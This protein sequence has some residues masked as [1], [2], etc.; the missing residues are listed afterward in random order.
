VEYSAG[1]LR[2]RKLSQEEFG[3]FGKQNSGNSN[4]LLNIS[5][6]GNGSNKGG[7]N[8]SVFSETMSNPDLDEYLFN[9]QT[10]GAAP[11]V[12]G[13]QIGSGTS[14]AVNNL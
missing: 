5:D 4:K 3:T 8:K 14:P 10:T 1:L 9:K 11:A 13:F 12:F 7:A 6:E 2:R